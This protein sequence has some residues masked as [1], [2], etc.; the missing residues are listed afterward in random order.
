ME[1]HLKRKLIKGE[2]VHHKD[3]DKRNFRIEN[4]RL[5]ANQDEHE[6]IHRNNYI[7]TGYW[8]ENRPK[9]INTVNYA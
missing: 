8:Y 1:A 7:N 3:G 5:C 4:L 2:I 9:Y 6:K